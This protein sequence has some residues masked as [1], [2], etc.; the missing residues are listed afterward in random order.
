MHLNMYTIVPDYKR[1]KASINNFMNHTTTQ[2]RKDGDRRTRSETEK[3]SCSLLFRARLQT[4]SV[5]GQTVNILGFMGH[6][7]VKINKGKPH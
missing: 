7:T 3:H 1:E 2:W 5:N 4:F 6:T